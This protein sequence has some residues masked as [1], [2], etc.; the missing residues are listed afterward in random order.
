VDWIIRRRS[1]AGIRDGHDYLRTEAPSFADAKRCRN[2]KKKKRKK[3]ERER[4]REKRSQVSRGPL[5]IRVK[6]LVPPLSAS[7]TYLIS[8][9]TALIMVVISKI[10]IYPD[11][12]FSEVLYF[13]R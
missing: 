1:R 10:K 11:Q 2:K 4:E 13:V 7:S 12:R 5:D 9:A 3:R 6:S 8:L